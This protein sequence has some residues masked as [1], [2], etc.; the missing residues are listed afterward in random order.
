MAVRCAFHF[1]ASPASAI[2]IKSLSPGKLLIQKNIRSTTLPL[3]LQRNS[4]TRLRHQAWGNLFNFAHFF[5]ISFKARGGILDRGKRAS[6]GAKNLRRNCRISAAPACEIVQS[7]PRK[8]TSA[9]I[10][11]YPSRE[12][13]CSDS[14]RLRL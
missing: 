3:Q 7:A 1:A 5:S 11:R 8:S 9:L 2:E 13:Y 14:N 12:P 10:C 4:S 6:A